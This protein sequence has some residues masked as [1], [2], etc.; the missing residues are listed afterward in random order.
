MVI[1][2]NKLTWVNNIKHLG[3]VLTNGS[4]IMSDDVMLKRAAYVN[5]NNELCQEFYFTDPNLKIQINNLFNTSFY[6]SVLWDMFGAEASRL[7][8][9]VECLSQKDAKYSTTN[10]QVF[11]RT[12]QSARFVK[13]VNKIGSCN[14]PSIINILNTIMCN[15]QSRTGSNIRNIL[16]KFRKTC[17]DDILLSDIRNLQYFEIPNGS[18]W[19]INSIKECIDHISGFLVSIALKSKKFEITSASHRSFIYIFCI[20]LL[21]SLNNNNNNNN[22]SIDESTIPE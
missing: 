8:K 7:E 15:C 3:N 22:L 14:K 5:R 16:L 21:I 4:N 9:N 12:Y 13:F 1:F 2:N 11:S 19:K 6:R 17:I 18:K 20:K 10:T